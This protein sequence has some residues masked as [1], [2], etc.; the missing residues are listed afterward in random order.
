MSTLTAPHKFSSSTSALSAAATD[1]DSAHDITAEAASALIQ[2]QRRYFATGSTQDVDF[3]IDALKRLAETIRSNE[4]AIVQALYDDF[5]KPETETFITEY[6]FVLEDIKHTLKHIRSWA[7]PE[8]VPT[9]IA[10]QPG[11]AKVYAIPFG[12][13]LII[14]PWNYPFQLLFAPLVGAIAA[15]NCVVLKPS[16]LAPAM[17]RLAKQIIES[18]FPPEFVA[19][20]EGG[21]PTNTRLLEEHWDYI[22]FT[23][24]T[25]VGRV[26][27]MAAAKHLTPTTL[28]LGGKSPCIVDKSA[29]LD[30]AARR[31]V[32]GKFVNAGQTCIAPDYLLLDKSIELPFMESVK[33]TVREFYGD[34]PERSPDYA[35]IINDRHFERLSGYLTDGEAF[36]GGTTNAAE[37]YIAP[38]VLRGVDAASRV[39]QEEIFGPILPVMTYSRLGEAIAFINERPK[40]LAL[41]VFSE[42]RTVQNDVFGKTSSGGGCVNDTLY[43]IAVPGLPFGGVGDSG[44]GGYHGKHSFDTFSHKRGVYTNT[45]L[46]DIPLR[47]APYGNKLS[48]LRRILG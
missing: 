23:G 20:V 2:A 39:M 22:F 45:T 44:I 34:E 18:V 9:P 40:P 25:E 16:E 6:S 30:V 19:V 14:S 42:D 28:E 48:L 4:S 47:Y 17:S 43:H 41:Y 27:A 15:G 35:R 3:R 11:G 29:N 38:T 33:A 12:V 7:K 1:T 24:G 46:L 26:I 36:I 13:T 10:A 37:R 21:V 5:R 32:W 31:I 8:R